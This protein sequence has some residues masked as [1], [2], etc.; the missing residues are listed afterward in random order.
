ML[1]SFVFGLIFFC[2]T[3]PYP[4]I[5][6]A[7]S[8]PVIGIVFAMGATRQAAALGFVYIAIKYLMQGSRTK[9]F[10]FICLAMSFHKSAIIMMPFCLTVGG[11]I[12][13]RQLLLC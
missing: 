8:M 4:W 9:Y 3:L 1:K 2:K 11:Q 6:L 5:S 7:I 13:K 12:K 10:I